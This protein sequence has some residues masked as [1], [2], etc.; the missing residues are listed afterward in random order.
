MFKKIMVLAMALGAMA[1][2]L[3]PV[4]ALANWQ[5]KGAKLEVS[6]TIALKGQVNVTTSAG[7]VQCELTPTVEFLPGTTGFIETFQTEGQTLTTEKCKGSGGLSF[8]Q[9]H[10][11][12]PTGLPY[13]T[14]QGTGGWK[15]HTHAATQTIEIMNGLIHAELVGFACPFNQVTVTPGTIIA[16]PNNVAEVSSVTQSGNLQVDFKNAKG[17]ET[18]I[19]AQVSGTLN[20]EGQQDPKTYG[21]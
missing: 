14:A 15:L 13:N 19:A 12:E 17:E 21:V 10:N 1:A 4:A 2:F 16:T 7:G 20:V 18:Q 8:C 9:V 5:E 6:K 3:L 11:L